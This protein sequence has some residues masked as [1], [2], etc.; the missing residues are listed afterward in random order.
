MTETE[1]TILFFI[2]STAAVAA[3]SVLLGIVLVRAAEVLKEMS[4]VSKNAAEESDR[5]KH[6]IDTVRAKIYEEGMKIRHVGEFLTKIGA[7][8]FR[9]KASRKNKKDIS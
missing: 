3:I 8:I 5:I 2:V 6:D 4:R 1:A 9:A 7:T